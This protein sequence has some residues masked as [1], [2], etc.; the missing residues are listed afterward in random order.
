MRVENDMREY[1]SM[2]DKH[3]I[4]DVR[5]ERI[6]KIRIMIKI[7]IEIKLRN[8]QRRK[9][10]HTHTHTRP[11]RKERVWEPCDPVDRTKRT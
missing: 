2:L 8:E 1:K 10:T 6:E 11:K 7:R 3:E 4:A 9:W 5:H